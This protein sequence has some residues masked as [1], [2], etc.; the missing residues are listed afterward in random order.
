MELELI[1][2]DTLVDGEKKCNYEKQTWEEEEKEL[3]RLANTLREHMDLE[4]IYEIM[5]ME[6]A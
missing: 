2:E 4:Y 1:D 3:Q 6:N 5:G